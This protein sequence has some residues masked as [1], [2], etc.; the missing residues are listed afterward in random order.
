MSHIQQ[1]YKVLFYENSTKIKYK[2]N[3]I[4]NRPHGHGSMYYNNEDNTIKYEGTFLEGDYSNFGTMYEEDGSIIF[5]GNF[6]KGEWS[7]GYGELY[8]DGYPVYH[9]FF[10]K[11]G[12]FDGHGVLFYKNCRKIHYIGDFKD[13]A[14]HGKGKVLLK[15]GKVFYEGDFCNDNFEGVGK[16][17]GC[18]GCLLYEGEM[19]E[20][21]FNGNGK[22][23]FSDG[24]TLKY[25]G[26][27]KDSF[28]HGFG[29]MYDDNDRHRIQYEGYF[30]KGK[31]DPYSKQSREHFKSIICKYDCLREISQFWTKLDDDNDQLSK[32][33]ISIISD[34]LFTE[35]KNLKENDYLG[36]MNFL[37]SI[38]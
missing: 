3:V 23:Y 26:S 36:G 20:S 35:K 2:G 16:C 10:S 17:F 1:E 18:N 37:K 15:N 24:Q 8:E 11:E 32:A 31:M 22:L 19:S 12:K 7:F 25:E 4:D 14:F 33:D 30:V 38:Y 21:L 27:F 29:K 6:E 34:V 9:G 13:G 5:R 28:F